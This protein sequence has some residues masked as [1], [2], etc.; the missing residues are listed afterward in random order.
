M[1]ARV[2]LAVGPL[3]QALLVPKDAIVFE[4]GKSPK[5]I[6]AR[7]DPAAKGT[8][9]VPVPVQLGVA[10]GDWIQVTGELRANESVIVIGNERVQPGQPVL[11]TPRKVAEG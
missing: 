6:L 1:L 7:N 4:E 9:A 3:Q 8:V 10:D 5:I 2:T 11:P